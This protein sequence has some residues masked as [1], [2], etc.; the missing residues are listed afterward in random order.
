[1]CIIVLI[2]IITE[3]AFAIEYEG[4]A[5]GDKVSNLEKA[6]FYIDTWYEPELY[7]SKFLVKHFEFGDEEY[8]MSLG[9]RNSA[10][11]EINYEFIRMWPDENDNMVI[12][13]NAPRIWQ[14]EY[15]QMNKQYKDSIIQ[16]WYFEIPGAGRVINRDYFADDC[17]ISL[18]YGPLATSV[19][20]TSMADRQQPSDIDGIITYTGKLS[21]YPESSKE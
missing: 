2:Q 12:R 5:I 17:C 1:M 15:E 10:I 21:D 3:V 7:Y 20:I 4:Y 14:A 8:R 9:I 19:F 16:E 11:F 13:I 6:G 18:R